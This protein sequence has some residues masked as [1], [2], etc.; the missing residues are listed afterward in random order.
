MKS[1]RAQIAAELVAAGADGV[2][3]ERLGEKLG[4]SRMAIAKHVTALREAGYGI[5]AVRGEG[6]RLH[7]L[8][9]ALAAVEVE[10]LLSDSLWEHVG[11]SRETGST[12]DDCKELARAGAPCGTVV[13]SGRQT[14]GKGRLGRTW[15]SPEG[16]V[17]LSALLKPSCG[18]SDIAPLAPACALGV[19]R[20]LE[21]LGVE[22]SVKWPNDVLIGDRKVA[23][24]LLEMS[25]EA[26]QINWIVVGC[27][28]NVTRGDSC[29]ENAAFVT[30][31]ADVV[32]SN[33]AVA[34]LDGIAGVYG[35]FQAGGFAA[36]RAE[37]EAHHMLSGRVVMVHDGTGRMVA[38]GEAVGVDDDGRLLVRDA[39][40]IVPV[41]AGEVT[42]RAPG[43]SSQ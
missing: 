21:S 18:P 38:A 1:R 4:I 6:Y 2:S 15:V 43:G 5:T 37:Y 28:I 34:V 8:P 41:V 26:D 11:G 39:S 20:G 16:G 12:N 33:V 9:V 35:E 40:G 17:Y 7:S 24:V 30:D 25:A 31:H 3:G 36:L 22:C 14:G 27:G 10:R 42:L 19:V 29:F 13:L 32:P 23:G